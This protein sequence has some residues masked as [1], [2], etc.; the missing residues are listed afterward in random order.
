M[1]FDEK[2]IC[3]VS[4]LNEYIKKLVYNDENL[5]YIAIKGEISNF[6]RG[7][8]GH[9]YFSLKD[10]KSIISA[11]MFSESAKKLTFYPK[12]GDE[13]ICFG[14]VNVYEA[15]GSYQLY[16]QHMELKGLGQLL[17]EFEELKKKLQ[18]EGL[19][20]ASK[21]KPIPEYPNAIGIISALNSAALKDILTNI[22]RRY[23]IADIYVFPSAVQGV[24]A[25]KELLKALTIAETYPLDTLIIGRGGGASEDLSAFNDETL[26]RA[27][28][29]C[30]IPV[31]AAVGHEID[32]TIL[33]F[34]ADI[35]VSTPTG[36]AEKATPDQYEIRQNLD[37][38]LDEMKNIIFHKMNLIK[39]EIEN[40]KASLDGNL[41]NKIEKLTSEIKYK[42][43]H[44]EALNPNN[45]LE[46]GYSITLDKDG[47]SI[48]NASGLEL[49]D[50]IITIFKDGTVTSEI[51]EI[52]KEK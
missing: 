17:V 26:A 41:K 13:V 43:E 5:R 4:Q 3:S 38:L 8:N 10:S 21:K 12:E 22:K 15:R 46:R 51:K 25:P 36:A 9:C 19:F 50:K 20:D 33:D 7:A 44:L 6:K 28:A 29:A 11:V 24:D 32:F 30:K 47:K 39:K 23:P 35:R 42:K 34:V 40:S 16:V 31:I 27:V 45:V 52:K 49:N 37:R 18:Q 48:K 2:M 14:S 1:Y